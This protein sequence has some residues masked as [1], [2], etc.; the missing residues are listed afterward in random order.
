MEDVSRH[1]GF[2][3]Q[4]LGEGLEELHH[5]NG[6][7][8]CK[9]Y[10]SSAA[11]FLDCREATGADARISFNIRDSGGSWISTTEVEKLAAVK[12][13]QLRT[14]GV[15]NPGGVAASLSLSTAELKSKFAAGQRCGVELDC[16]DSKPTGVIRVSL[17]PE[18]IISDVD[19]FLAFIADVFVERE[20]PV[21]VVNG[22][23]VA[24]LGRHHGFPHFT[25]TA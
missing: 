8:A 13:I 2:L 1:C 25:F 18:N 20:A 16:Q 23:L 22:L 17:G 24:F 5:Y 6:L 11:S 7:A 19:S 10:K 12:S 4:R 9:I 21:N 14:G 15:C 3:A